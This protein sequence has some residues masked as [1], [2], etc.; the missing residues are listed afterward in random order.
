MNSRDTIDKNLKPIDSNRQWVTFNYMK[1]ILKKIK[2]HKA[3]HMCD[4]S[5][6]SEKLHS[7][8]NGIAITK[9]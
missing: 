5:P 4:V 6:I 7:K 1:P 8:Q 3:L 9:E 2:K